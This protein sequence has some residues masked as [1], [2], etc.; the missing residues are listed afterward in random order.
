MLPTGQP[1]DEAATLAHQLDA[2][3]EPYRQNAIDW[4]Q[5]YTQLPMRDP[6]RDLPRLVRDLN[7]GVRARFLEC[8]HLILEEA[9]R[10]FGG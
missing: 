8:T 9:T 3:S 5:G 6:R 2:L 7:P 4:L 1:D 10:Y